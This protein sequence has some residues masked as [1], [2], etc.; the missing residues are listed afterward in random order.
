MFQVGQKVI[1]G[2]HGVCCIT[3]LEVKRS[4][5]EKKEFYCLEPI[6]Q[7]GAVFYV[8]TGNSAAVA[9]LRPILNRKEFEDLI[10]AQ[11]EREVLWIEDE[12]LRKQRY[13]ELIA[14]N[15]RAELISMVS[16][17]SRHKRQQE[18]SGRKFHICDDNFLRD[19]TRLL[20]GEF[21]LVLGIPRSEVAQY[22][23]D[24]LETK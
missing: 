1:Y 9:K 7:P 22:M 21:A 11:K 8:P 24:Q 20:S 17:L 5:K 2:I 16:A 4:G 19:A 10:N 14:R 23:K 13:R 6:D 12:N 18:E 15:D 3:A